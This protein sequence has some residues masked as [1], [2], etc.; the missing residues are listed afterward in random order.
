MYKNLKKMS[1]KCLK[2]IKKTLKILWK[3]SKSIKILLYNENVK[4]Y[5]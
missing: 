1:K 3:E 5:E 4:E 2:F